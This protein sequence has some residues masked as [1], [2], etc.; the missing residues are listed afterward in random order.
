M[1]ERGIVNFQSDFLRRK[2]H[3]ALIRAIISPIQK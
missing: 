2:I 1:S 3:N